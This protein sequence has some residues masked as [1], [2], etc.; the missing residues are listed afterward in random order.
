[1][2]TEPLPR[3]GS[4]LCNIIIFG[5]QEKREENYSE[6]MDVV[7]KWLSESMKAEKTIEKTDHVSRLGGTGGG[8]QVLIKLTLFY[9]K[10]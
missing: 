6:T 10:L 9:K 8:R 5:L 1:V 7:A 3:N 4:T 2:F